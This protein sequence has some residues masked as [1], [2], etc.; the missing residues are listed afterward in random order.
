MDEARK[1]NSY[2]LAV[3]LS[4]GIAGRLALLA[5]MALLAGLLWLPRTA[6]AALGPRLIPL[7]PPAKLA[8]YYGWPSVVNGAGG[9]VNRAAAAFRDF[10]LVVFGDGLEHPSHGDHARTRQI[11]GQVI[12]AGVEVY[13]YVDMGVTTQNLPLATAQQYVDEWQ[14]MGVTGIFWDDAGYD[15]GV[16]RPRQNALVDYTHARGLRAFVNAWNPADVLGASSQGAPRLGAGDVYLAEAWLV[17]DGRYTDL[18]AWAA[19]ADTLVGYRSGTG[20]RLAAIS[21]GSWDGD[22]SAA[23]HPYQMSRWGAAIYGL[24][25]FGYADSL[26]AAGGAAANRLWLPPPAAADYGSVFVQDRVSHEF[27]DAY[28]VRRTD[29]GAIVVAGDG[30]TWGHGYFKRDDVVPSVTPQLSAT[31]THTSAP[32][33]TGTPTEASPLTATPSATASPAGMA[34]PTRSPTA[35]PTV[36][37]T[38]T[39][40][41][42]ETSTVTPTPTRSPTAPP[43][44]TPTPTRPPTETPT[45]T[46]TPTRTPTETPTVTPTP[47]S[48]VTPTPTRTAQSSPGVALAVALAGEHSTVLVG[49]TVGFSVTLTNHADAAIAYLSLTD[50]F[51]PR[52]LTYLAADPAPQA[53]SVGD[54]VGALTWDDLIRARGFPLAR[55]EGLAVSVRFQV[56][57]PCEN[58]FNTALVSSAVDNSGLS[59]PGGLAKTL[60]RSIA[61][62][63]IGGVVFLDGDGDGQRGPGEPAVAVP[64]PVEITDLATATSVTVT[65]RAD[66]SYLYDWLLPGSYRVSAP[67]HWLALLRTTAAPLVVTVG[68]GENLTAVDI[69]YVAPTGLPVAG[70][71]AERT[72]GG[73]LVRWEVTLLWAGAGFAVWRAERAEGPAALVASLLPATPGETRYTWLDTGALSGAAYWYDL[74]S[75]PDGQRFGPVA[76]AGQ[77]PP[78]ARTFLPAIMGGR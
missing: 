48:A 35:P 69:G 75:L 59:M 7:V 52:C 36:T 70:L 23:D 11:V 10:N 19:K 49:D 32:A 15:Y 21:T 5:L 43:T 42:T 45:V 25:A 8:I 37:P 57:S 54:T 28:H 18:G 12:A 50:V 4:A 74:Q 39:R 61:P 6:T 16:D 56:R 38:P 33:P 66:G 30:A 14:A 60:F 58:G 78:G 20:V 73:V 2:P 41:P 3:Y 34:T 62:A 68:A 51:D 40:T 1:R 9:D 26:Y 46:P 24:D 22:P 72:S 53:S 17:S 29:L 64:V 63:R 44:V 71:A 13:G 31:P 67:S 76:V 77:A 47:T 27:A 65:S 55:G